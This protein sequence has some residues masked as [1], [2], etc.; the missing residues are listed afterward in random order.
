MDV[1][2]L[3]FSKAFDKVD[4]LITLRK[5]NSLGIKGKIG[6]WIQSFLTGRSQ[7][8]LVNGSKSTACDVK[9]GV[10]QGSVLGPILFLIL[11]GDIDQ[12]VLHSFV[13]S[14]ADDS[15]VTKAVTCQEDTEYLQNDLEAIYKWTETNNMVLNDDKFEC[16]RYGPNMDLKT[17]TGYKSNTGTS[18]EVTDHV[19]D[20]GITMSSDCTFKEH[21][22]QTISTARSLAGW[23][24]RTFSTRDSLPMMTLWKTMVLPKLDYCC[25]LWNPMEKAYIQAIELVQRSFLRRIC[26]LSELSYWDQLKHIKLYSVERRRERY[27]V[28][29]TWKVLE[30]LV[31]NVSTEQERKIISKCTSRH[32][33]KCY[34]HT[35]PNHVSAKVKSARYASLGYRGPLLFNT[36]PAEIRNIT[37]VPVDIFK[38]KL[39]KFLSTVPDEPQIPGYTQHRRA[40]TNSLL[41]MANFGTWTK[42]NGRKEMNPNGSGCPHRLE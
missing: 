32:G 3:D 27:F 15:R 7:S 34:I 13:S 18:I 40:E 28:I 14:F 31:P 16:L 30:G 37:K 25:T 8:V 39:D 33:R 6:R 22:A 5:L 38:K 23:I 42:Q 35:V 41:C 2:Y 9:S 29:Y 26:A 19:K 12:D 17:N 21:I 1:I 4:F 36:I 20:L 24:L 10:P 11:L